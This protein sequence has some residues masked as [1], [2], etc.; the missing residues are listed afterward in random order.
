S[1]HL[2]AAYPKTVLIPGIHRE[3]RPRLGRHRCPSTPA[4]GSP[5]GDRAGAAAATGPATG[6]AHAALAATANV[7]APAD[8]AVASPAAGASNRTDGSRA[9]PDPGNHPLGPGAAG[10]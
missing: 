8:T 10:D 6:P 5:V 3:S 4:P 7:P 1:A 2:L 9:E